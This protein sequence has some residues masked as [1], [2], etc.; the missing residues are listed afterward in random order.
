MAQTHEDP[1]TE[2]LKAADSTAEMTVRADPPGIPEEN[3]EPVHFSDVAQESS[4][5]GREGVMDRVLD[6][7]SKS[8][9]AERALVGAVLNTKDL[10]TSSLQL[11]PVEKVSHPR[12]KTLLEATVATFGRA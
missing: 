10:E 8:D 9:V 4:K 7:K 5:D 1:L 11:Q 2:F 6:Y 12:A 3:T